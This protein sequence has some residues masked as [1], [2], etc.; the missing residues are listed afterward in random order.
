MPGT[1]SELVN[2][3]AV[4]VVVTTAGRIDLLD[5]CLDALLRQSLDGHRYEIIVVD[6][7]PNHNTRQLVAVW[8]A[9]ACANGPALL[10]LAKPGPPCPA[11]ARNRGW[12]AARAPIIAFTEDDT[13]PAPRWL[14]HGLD[15]FDSHVDVLCGRIEIPP[16]PAATGARPARAPAG[17]GPCLANCFCRKALLAALDGFDERFRLAG[18]EAQ[19]WHFRLLGVQARIVHSAHALVVR[20]P[21][22]APWGVSLFELQQLAFDALLYKKHPALYRKNVRASPHWEHYLIVAL[23]L[24]ALLGLPLGARTLALWAGS[25][26]LVLTLA[27]CA[28]RLRGSAPSGAHLLE[29]LV[30]SALMPPL[31]VYWRLAGAIRF[32][33]RFA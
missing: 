15:S 2:V 19:D 16:D 17:G 5:R 20:P 28:R 22:Q 8:R 29:M 18:R 26:W 21:R 23:L 10:Y 14:R 4:S 13:V 24:C 6:D 11:A 31:A 33:V 7:V 9:S 1:V 27:L 30:T 32:R 12:R 25:A 3:P